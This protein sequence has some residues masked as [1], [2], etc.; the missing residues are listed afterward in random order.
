M[1]K[2]DTPCMVIWKP[3]VF[4]FGIP[5]SLIGIIFYNLDK[6]LGFLIN[7]LLWIF[8]GLLLR[9]VLIYNKYKINTIK[10]NWNRYDAT[11]VQIL[12]N[13]FYK[14]GSYITARVICTAINSGKIEYKSSYFLLTAYDSIE[15]LSAKLYV[16][17]DDSKK[18][19]IELFRMN[20][21]S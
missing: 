10:R 21:N 1:K 19:T 2:I 11:V 9:G 4:L 8:I 20:S 7:G 13:Y 14:I 5:F 12:P 6:G 17:N 15:N 3:M 16:K 18:Y